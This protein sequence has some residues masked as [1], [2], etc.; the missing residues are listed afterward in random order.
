MIV[1]LTGLPCSGKTTIG[2]ALLSQLRQDGCAAELLDGD[3]IRARLWPELGFTRAER[4][5]N[6]R[7][8][9]IMAE[10]LSCHGIIA[11][12]AAISPYRAIRD[13]IRKQDVRFV[14][15]YVNTPLEI[16]ERRDVKGMYAKAR[17]GEIPAFTGVSD[18]YEPPLHPEVECM[19]GR[20]TPEESMQKILDYIREKVS[21]RRYSGDLAIDQA[22][23]ELQGAGDGI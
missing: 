23:R 16:C 7:R 9:G 5:E 15:V 3:E 13:E 19:A 12:V 2:R 18:P 6:I 20:E 14:E 10:S 21:V 4:D 22:A 17:A 8:L 11:I 1:F